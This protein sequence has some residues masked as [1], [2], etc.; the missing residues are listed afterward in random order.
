MS[1]IAPLPEAELETAAAESLAFARKLMGYV[2]QSVPVMARWPALLDAFRGLVNVV[3]GPG[4]VEP[5][6]KRLVGFMTSAAAGCRYC[7][8]HAALGAHGQGVPPEKIEALWHYTTSPLFSAAER[9]ALDLAF[10]AGQHPNGA[11]DEHFRRAGEHFSPEELTEIV[12]VIAMFGFLNRWNDTLATPLEAAPKAFAEQHL[13][14]G[15]WTAGKHLH[16]RGS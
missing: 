3:Y 6:L 15:G 14:E 9:A 2:P 1:R 7:Q 10:A 5:G 11:T 8:S 13:T 16:Q 4:R 12:A